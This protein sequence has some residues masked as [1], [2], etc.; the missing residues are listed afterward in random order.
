M[1]KML[2]SLTTG[3]AGIICFIGAWKIC[4]SENPNWPYFLVMGIIVIFLACAIAA[5]P[6]DEKEDDL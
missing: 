4:E 3:I 2:A 5:V 1:K 6:E